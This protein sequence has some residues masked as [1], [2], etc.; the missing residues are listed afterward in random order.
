M[1]IISGYIGSGKTSK[2]VLKLVENPNSYLVTMTYERSA[3]LKQKYPVVAERI[4]S[5]D[6]VQRGK[7]RGLVASLLIDDVDEFLSNL[8]GHHVQAASLTTLRS[9]G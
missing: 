8:L 3:Y 6:Q 4:V 5:V 9:H 1:E 2:L 7:L